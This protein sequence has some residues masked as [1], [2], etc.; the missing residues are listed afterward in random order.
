MFQ[1]LRSITIRLLVVFAFAS[2]LLPATAGA[3][4]LSDLTSRWAARYAATPAPSEPVVNRCVIGKISYCEKYGGS[5]CESGNSSPQAKAD[6]A[7]WTR[8]CVACHNEM[9][10][11][12]GGTRTNVA[13]SLCTRCRNRW[14]ACMQ[15]ADGNFWPNRMRQK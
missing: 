15:E 7:R 6:C 9:P 4:F 10:S 8:A 3:T 1:S 11:C 13:E 14:N 12:L 2:I 5:R